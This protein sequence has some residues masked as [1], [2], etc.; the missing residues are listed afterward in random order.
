MENNILSETPIDRMFLDLDFLVTREIAT[1]MPTAS[2]PESDSG[3]QN[4]IDES[5]SEEQYFSLDLEAPLEHPTPTTQPLP[6][7]DLDGD[8]DTN[9]S[10]EE[11]KDAAQS[12]PVE[13]PHDESPQRN[14]SDEQTRSSRQPT[15]SIAVQDASTSDARI[16]RMREHEYRV[17]YWVKVAR[18]D[19][20]RSRVMKP[21]TELNLRRQAL[22][23][24]T[25]KSVKKAVKHKEVHLIS[26][27]N[28]KTRRFLMLR[29]PRPHES[30]VGIIFKYPPGAKGL[31]TS[32]W[33][34]VTNASLGM[35]KLCYKPLGV[36]EKWQGW[37]DRLKT[38][39][40]VRGDVRY[41]MLSPSAMCTVMSA[42]DVE[43]P[44]MNMIEALWDACCTDIRLL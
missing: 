43:D 13:I 32:N 12:S 8:I 37:V 25:V 15:Q 35:E 26:H 44:E 1:T 38:F 28:K 3:S 6:D 24:R 7:P 18:N 17:G 4:S 5:V 33:T 23:K 39:A 20:L 16:K 40:N 22:L 9:P 27:L 2:R 11:Q 34:A 19:I 29:F 41:A 31:K 30:G 42:E 14:S 10:L 36:G 21:Y